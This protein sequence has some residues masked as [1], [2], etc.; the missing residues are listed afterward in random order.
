MD[1]NIR[2][3]TEF[4]PGLL[5]AAAGLYRLAGWVDPGESC[6]FLLPALRNSCAV[7]VARCGG[8][9]AGMGR[10]LGDNVSDAYI[11]DVVVGPGF[12]R[13]GGGGAIVKGLVAELRSRGVTWIALVG[14]PGTGEFYRSLGFDPPPGYT[15]WRAPEPGGKRR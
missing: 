10:A 14:A 8:A 3:E 7:C 9:V 4:S 6:D 12:R 15:F 5:R 2:I 13:R 11:Q 1:F